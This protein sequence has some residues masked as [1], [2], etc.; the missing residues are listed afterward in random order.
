MRQW[1]IENEFSG[2][3]D[4]KIPEMTDEFVES[5]TNRYIELY[6]KVTGETF[7]RRSYEDIHTQIENNVNRYLE[8]GAL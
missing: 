4:Q 6:E 7:V 1:L 8:S 5:V 2:Q 3:K